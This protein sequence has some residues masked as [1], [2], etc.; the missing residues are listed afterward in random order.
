MDN[1]QKGSVAIGAYAGEDSQQESAIS[2]GALAGQNY[3]QPSA[4]AIGNNSG[5]NSQQLSAVAIGNNS[6]QNYQQP[7]AVAIGNNS[8][9]NYQ[10]PSAVAIGSNAGLDNQQ[11]LAIAIG[12]GAG[13]STQQQYAVAIGNG[14][15]SENQGKNSIAVG[16]E[17]GLNS[18]GQNAIAIGNKAGYINQGTTI[19]YNN[20]L[21]NDDGEHKFNKISSSLDGSVVATVS[22]ATEIW[23]SEDSGNSWRN[24]VVNEDYKFP[25]IAVSGDGTTIVSIATPNTDLNPGLYYISRDYGQTWT[26]K[27]LPIF[28]NDK[29]NLIDIVVS[30]D[31][32]VILFANKIN[33]D[34]YGHS[35][36]LSVDNF[37]TF[38]FPVQKT[39]AET[40][41][42]KREDLYIN[43]LAM[44]SDG[45]YYI[46]AFNGGPIY[47]FDP[48]NEAFNTIKETQLPV[49]NNWVGC[50]C[51]SDGLHAAVV[52]KGPSDY[53]VY[54][55]NDTFTTWEKKVEDE[56]EYTGISVSDDGATMVACAKSGDFYLSLNY[57]KQWTILHIDEF[58]TGVAISFKDGNPGNY[59]I[60]FSSN[61]YVVCMAIYT[62]FTAISIG[63][64]AGQNYQGLNAIAIG[65]SSGQN[66]Q[67]EGTVAIGNGAGYSFQGTNAIAIGNAAGSV[68]QGTN[69]IAIGRQAGSV[70]QGKYAIAI[71]FNAGVDS[72][73][74]NSI[75]INASDSKINSTTDGFFVNPIRNKMTENNMFYNPETKE[76][77]Y[78]KQ[79]DGNFETLN[80]SNFLVVDGAISILNKVGLNV[81][82]INGGLELTDYVTLT[83]KV[84]GM[85]WSVNENDQD[86]MRVYQNRNGQSPFWYWNKVGVAGFTSDIRIKED[87]ISMSE[88]DDV[89]LIKSLKPAFFSYKDCGT[90]AIGFIAQDIV[91]SILKL[92]TDK[93]EYYKQIISNFDEYNNEPDNE[94][95]V[96]LGV[97]K[98]AIFPSL[99]NVSKNLIS[100]VEQLEK[101]NKELKADMQKIKDFL[102]IS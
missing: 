81:S 19:T 10:Q 32:K 27:P 43:S 57:G 33:G 71:G 5:Q 46:C 13:Q 25:S 7:S 74:P 51:S 47:V 2:I 97:S 86:R 55:S 35:M 82:R 37:E 4:V 88:N 18:Q 26:H 52:T 54:V 21:S 62:G 95:K 96:L 11:A 98:D 79:V 6:G 66:N 63:N 72:Q 101:E 42:P 12:S 100:R 93:T 28:Y 50:S 75:I 58:L 1:Q 31:G 8:G 70:N 15:G 92:K 83:N 91:E 94:K 99:V 38:S 41:T 34:D 64:Y 78:S 102:N 36:Y 22:K 76:I 3:Q 16:V 68:Q 24:T 29:P 9:Q 89:N 23:V 49:D 85:V 56:A 73:N 77:T 30:Y 61:S 17:A 20:I 90:K 69:S 40:Q 39:W 44:S 80:L 14:A 53:G 65:N 60:Y 59:Y 87:I 84:T 45:K 48:T 67:Q